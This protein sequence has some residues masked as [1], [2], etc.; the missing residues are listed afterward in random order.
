[1]FSRS[2]KRICTGQM[3]GLRRRFIDFL[4]R[5]SATK[6]VQL[7]IF[8]F[9]IGYFVKPRARGT[10]P[11]QWYAYL[12]F[13]YHFFH[14]YFP[15]RV[16]SKKLLRIVQYSLITVVITFLRPR[17]CGTIFWRVWCTESLRTQ[18]NNQ[19][20]QLLRV[21]NVKNFQHTGNARCRGVITLRSK[22]IEISTL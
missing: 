14:F 18:I 11:A 15:V 4:S 13:T 1:M 9:R 19:S 3:F 8:L 12:N 22:Q 2:L 21:E 5:A 17:E 6:H 10:F 20:W 7:G 16:A